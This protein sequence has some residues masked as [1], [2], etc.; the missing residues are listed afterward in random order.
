MGGIALGA[1]I[2]F[3]LSWVHLKVDDPEVEITLTAIAAYGGYLLGE[4]LH[5]SG[6]LTVVA[7]GLV[8]GNYGRPRGMSE[9]TRSAVTVFWDYVAFVLN[10]VVFLLIG[11]DA[12]WST[13]VSQVWVMLG[14]IFA[15]LADSAGSVYGFLALQR[16]SCSSRKLRCPPIICC[17]ECS[18]LVSIDLLWRP[19]PHGS[20]LAVRRY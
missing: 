10:S 14:A 5:V 15:V 7:A 4:S 8:L 2:G 9:R 16:S 17:S 6:L 3:A 1:A 19:V 13:L 18:G 12:P 20:E 11:A